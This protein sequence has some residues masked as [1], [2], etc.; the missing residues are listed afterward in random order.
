MSDGAS[1][2]SAWVLP[3]VLVRTS[4]WRAAPARLAVRASAIAPVRT[5]KRRE[6]KI[7]AVFRLFV[8]FDIFIR[9]TRVNNQI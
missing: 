8:R 2:T 3:R 1:L 7:H 9:Q 4:K 5:P 6:S